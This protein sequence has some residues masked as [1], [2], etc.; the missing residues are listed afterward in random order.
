[1]RALQAVIYTGFLL[2]L[3]GGAGTVVGLLGRSNGVRLPS[4]Y[5]LTAGVAVSGLAL[6][7]GLVVGLYHLYLYFFTDR[8]PLSFFATARKEPGE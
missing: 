7:L 1:M 4:M 8:R 6:L 3:L 5:V 2:V